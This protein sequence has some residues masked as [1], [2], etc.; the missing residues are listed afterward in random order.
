MLC[1]YLVDPPLKFGGLGVFQRTRKRLLR[2]EQELHASFVFPHDP[3][4]FPEY[5]LGEW[6]K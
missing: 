5:I 4:N 6:I 1:Q 2:L 3:W